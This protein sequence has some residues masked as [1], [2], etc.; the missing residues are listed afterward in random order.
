ML[1]ED[2]A[3][4]LI[5]DEVIHVETNENKAGR[6]WAGLQKKI[7]K[8]ASYMLSVCFLSELPE[9]DILLFHYI[10]KAFQSEKSIETNFGDKH[11]LELSKIYKKVTREAERMIMFVRFQKTAD[12]IFFAPIEPIYNVMPMIIEHFKDRF[13]DQKWVIYDLKRNCG[14]YYDLKTTEEIVLENPQ[15][16]HLSGMLDNSLLAEEEMQYQTLWK[17]YFKSMA[18]KERLN[19][20]LHKQLL[21]KRFWKYLPEKRN[22]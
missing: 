3:L 13:S 17:N 22:C 5:Y 11:V 1:G 2:N 7:S 12:D 21:P 20:Q 4:P 10:F 19:P 16:N 9:I 15:F 8:E 18:I 6:V 14:I